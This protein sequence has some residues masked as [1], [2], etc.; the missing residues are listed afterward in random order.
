VTRRAAA[1]LAL[2]AI[3]ALGPLAGCGGGGADARGAKYGETVLTWPRGAGPAFPVLRGTDLAGKPLSTADA[4]GKV[5]VLNVWGSWCGPC[6]Q[7]TPALRAASD[8]LMPKGVRF[9]GLDIQERGDVIGARTYER[10]A[11]IRYPSFN[12]DGGSLLL[13]LRGIAVTAP[14]QTIVVGPDGHV[15][16]RYVAPITATTLKDLVADAGG[17]AA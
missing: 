12:D 16:A 8:A 17:P 1:L 13:Q 11:G 10:K 5:L 6:R 9:V 15:T 14:P 4:R 2:G 3:G 7:E